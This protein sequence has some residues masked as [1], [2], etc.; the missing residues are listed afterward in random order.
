MNLVQ[1]FSSMAHIE[2][3]HLSTHAARVESATTTH[4]ATTRNLCEQRF[5][6][7][8]QSLRGEWPQLAATFA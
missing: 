8:G 2:A 7:V 6:P 3:A 5:V 4:A 1:F